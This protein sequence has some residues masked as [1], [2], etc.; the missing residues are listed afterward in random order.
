[1]PLTEIKNGSQ[2]LGHQDNQLLPQARW[3]RMIGC[4]V[5]TLIRATVRGRVTITTAEPRFGNQPRQRLIPVSAFPSIVRAFG[6]ITVTGF[7]NIFYHPW[8]HDA[9]TTTDF[10]VS[11]P[12]GLILIYRYPIEV[13]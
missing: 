3:A 7:D 10:Q 5:D 1:M 12:S 2:T 9:D 4:G 8:A 6:E 13:T 11:P